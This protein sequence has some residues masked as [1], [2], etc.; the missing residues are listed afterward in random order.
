[1]IVDTYVTKCGHSFCYKY[2]HQS[3]EDNNRHT[4]YYYEVDNINHLYTNF[5]VNELILKQKQRLEEKRFKL[6]HSVSSTNGHRWQTFQDLLETD[7]D[8]LDLA[9]VK[10][11]LELLVQAGSAPKGQKVS[12]KWAFE[13]PLDSDTIGQLGA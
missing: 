8:N 5:L 1:M 7:Q 6:D 9:N 10:L 4:K 2:I 3:L 13:G 11:M 12:Q